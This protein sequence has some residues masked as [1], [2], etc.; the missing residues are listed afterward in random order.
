MAL[1]W[2]LMVASVMSNLRAMTLLDSPLVKHFRISLS[3]AESLQAARSDS[4]D[5]ATLVS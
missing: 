5:P 1:T 2:A 4:F 3:R